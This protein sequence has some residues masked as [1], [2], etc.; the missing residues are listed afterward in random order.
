MRGQIFFAQL[1]VVDPRTRSLGN[2]NQQGSALLVIV[3]TQL[4]AIGDVVQE[5][6]KSDCRMR[7]CPPFRTLP[8]AGLLLL[9]RLRFCRRSRS[10]RCRGWCMDSA[11]GRAALQLVMEASHSTWESRRMIRATT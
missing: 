10:N 8:N 5:H 7:L 9:G 11:P 6:R 4:R 2:S 3:G 1:N